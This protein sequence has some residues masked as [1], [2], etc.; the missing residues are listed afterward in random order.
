MR[1]YY[2]C[3]SC[4][5]GYEDWWLLGWSVAATTI[6]CSLSFLSPISL[7]SFCACWSLVMASV[8]LLKARDALGRDRLRNFRFE[9]VLP[10]WIE[11]LVSDAAPP[12]QGAATPKSRF[13]VETGIWYWRLAGEPWLFLAAAT[14]WFDRLPLAAIK[15]C[16]AV[17]NELD[18][19]V[20]ESAWWSCPLKLLV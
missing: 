6:I 8:F 9:S 20:E 15:P 16:I 17:F 11:L 18:F 14:G 1:D 7:C 12:P 3:G 19:L 4:D 13:Y 5:L 2:W 10:V